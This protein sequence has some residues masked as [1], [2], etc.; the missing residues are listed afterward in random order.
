MNNNNNTGKEHTLVPSIVGSMGRLAM[1]AS[2]VKNVT[3][4]DILE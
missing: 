4:S 1:L 3:N 2:S